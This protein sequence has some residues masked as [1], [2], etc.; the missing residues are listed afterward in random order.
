MIFVCVCIKSMSLCS[1]FPPFY[2]RL[3][4]EDETNSN[5]CP[6]YSSESQLVF[7]KELEFRAKEIAQCL[8]TPAPSPGDQ[9]QFPEP[10]LD[11]LQPL[12]PS[13]PGD[14]RPLLHL[15]APEKKM[16]LGFLSLPPV[17]VCVSITGESGHESMVPSRL[18][19]VNAMH[20]LVILIRCLV[21]I[22]PTVL[23]KR[24]T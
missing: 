7:H 17:T 6:D 23:E 15:L 14:W 10:T 20:L 12:V 4:P 21:C 9:L 19:Q 2:S 16:E 11:G 18:W 5:P 22:S 3:S 1:L 24:Q 13:F 8:R